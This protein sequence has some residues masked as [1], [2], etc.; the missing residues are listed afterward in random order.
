[1]KEQEVVRDLSL[2]KKWM[3]KSV[4]QGYVPAQ[5]KLAMMYYLGVGVVRD[6][7]LS[8]EW[9]EKAAD[10]GYAPAQDKLAEMY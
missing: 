3:E 9:L 4:A 2:V 6:L 5:Y 1:M 7:P 8:K 10:Q